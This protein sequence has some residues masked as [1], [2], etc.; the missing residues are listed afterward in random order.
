MNNIRYDLIPAQGITEVS[1]VLTHKLE[2]YDKNKWREGISWTEVLSSLKYHLT[3]FEQGIDYNEDG[4]L[5]IAEV[6]SNALLLCEYY[7]IYPHGDDRPCLMRNRPIIALDIDD[8]CL[9]FKGSFQKRFGKLNDYWAGSYNI[10]EQLEKIKDDKEFW[11]NLPALHL[12][13]FEPSM[14]ITS[15]SI[16]V[17]WTKENL[18]KMGFPCAPVYSV[19]FNESKLELL[20]KHNC[21]ILIDDKPDNY[22]EAT[23]AGIFCY[24][25]HSD[26]NAW[27]KVPEHRRIHDLNLSF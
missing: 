13:S 20:K 1:K 18:Q 26:H 6:A 9:D 7:K 21:S 23:N 22:K 24:L 16:P 11:T 8:V 14:Y 12:P 2:K 3:Q 17:E 10:G 4:D 15:R 27:F 19:P 5:N 25:M